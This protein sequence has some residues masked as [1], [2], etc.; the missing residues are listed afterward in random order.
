[1]PYKKLDGPPPPE[2][3][4]LHNR[5][6]RDNQRSSR[7][8]RKELIDE[9]QQ[10][11]AV[12]ERRGVQAT[13]EMQQAARR[14]AQENERLRALLMRKG[15]TKDEVEEWLHG[16]PEAAVDWRRPVGRPPPTPAPSSTW[17]PP[18]PLSA[19]SFTSADS[20]P[21][22]GRSFAPPDEG[23]TS[24]SP[25]SLVGSGEPTAT[26][27]AERVATCCTSG[28]ETSCEVAAAILA[29]MQGHG[30]PSRAR[31]ALGCTGPSD[32]TVK[33]T[34]VLELLDEVG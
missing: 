34:R 24:V 1:M 22:S 20:V 31:A 26:S 3:K 21:R 10:R 17:Y 25:A 12:H 27:L 14:V 15:V 5:R 8:R 2:V 32:C 13:L 7:A 16:S 28:T 9:L 29:N 23:H 30:D 4:Q 19:S 33:N 6:A 11:L 18:G